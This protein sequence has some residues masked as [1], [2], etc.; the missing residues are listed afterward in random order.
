MIGAVEVV[1]VVGGVILVISVA[2]GIGI[3]LRIRSLDRAEERRA[4]IAMASHDADE[5]ASALVSASH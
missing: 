4:A 3:G 5:P 1:G 2:A